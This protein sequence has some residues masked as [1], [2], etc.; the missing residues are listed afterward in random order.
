MVYLTEDIQYAHQ[1][2]HGMQQLQLSEEQIHA[3]TLMEIEKIMRTMGSFLNKI[4]QMPKPNESLLHELSN[5]L[6]A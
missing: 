3:Y 2:K 1:K 4:K 5:R 6:L